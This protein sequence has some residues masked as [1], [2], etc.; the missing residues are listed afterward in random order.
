MLQPVG[1]GGWE[2]AKSK[3]NVYIRSH[4][5]VKQHSQRIH[6]QHSKG[7]G[8][9][10]YVNDLQENRDVLIVPGT[11]GNQLLHSLYVYTCEDFKKK[12]AGQAE[13]S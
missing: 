8:S 10:Q 2:G 9:A 7:H 3:F 1:G 12:M 5:C 13:L 4:E 11:A 6:L